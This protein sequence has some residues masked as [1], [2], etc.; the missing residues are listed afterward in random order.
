MSNIP[1]DIETA[2]NTKLFKKFM[3]SK[4]KSSVSITS[5]S[6]SG[7]RI[8]NINVNIRSSL[9]E[10]NINKFGN[11]NNKSEFYGKTE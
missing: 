9:E 6:V 10:T 1:I 8:E 2:K 11:S 5:G 4:N 3:E 7:P